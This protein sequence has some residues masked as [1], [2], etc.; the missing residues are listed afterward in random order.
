VAGLH[1]VDLSSMW[2]GPLCAQI[3]QAAGAEVTKVESSTRPD[4]ARATP[5]FFS[6]L[7]PPGQATVTLDFASPAGRR[8]LAALIASADVV[9]EA[10]RPRALEQLGVDAD[11]VEDR[12][13][14]VWL[15]ITGY[16]R[17]VPGRDW[18]AFGDDAAVAGGL[19]AWDEVGGPVFCGDAIA[20]PLSGLVGAAA[21]LRALDAGG[22]RLIDLALSREAAA[23]A[24]GPHWGTPRSGATA[25]RAGWE[26]AGPDGPVAVADPARPDGPPAVRC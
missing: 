26:V 8:E 23:A 16:G 12:R 19:V 15:S 7:H 4:G 1:L 20:D 25:G 18:V 3:L 2:A 17:D 10:S 6:W 9:I 22:G 11:R 5:A 24:A 13:G 21:V 14:R